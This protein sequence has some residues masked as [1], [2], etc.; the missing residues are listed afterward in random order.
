MGRRG[1]HSSASLTV[2]EGGQEFNPQ[3]LLEPLPGMTDVQKD[4]WR[5]VI[6]TEPRELFQTSVQQEF[7]RSYCEAVAGVRGV[8]KAINEFDISWVKSREGGRKYRE[9]QKSKRE[10]IYDMRTFARDLRLTNRSRYTAETA[11]TL[12][13]HAA[14]DKFPWET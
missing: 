10:N 14:T 1:R 6:R 13:K 4:I 3:R 11:H 12:A 8:Q 7:L 5:D 9:L 2:I